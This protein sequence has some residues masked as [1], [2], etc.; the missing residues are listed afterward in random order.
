ME[1]F[2]RA[3][4]GGRGKPTERL[5]QYFMLETKVSWTRAGA[6]GC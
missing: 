6:V 2:F 3:R 5:L 4:K 1:C